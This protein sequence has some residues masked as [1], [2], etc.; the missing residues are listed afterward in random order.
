ML[1]VEHGCFRAHTTGRDL[2]ERV[3]W[4]GDWMRMVERNDLKMG[5]MGYPMNPS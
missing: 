5:S 3:L 2:K 1:Y 4:S